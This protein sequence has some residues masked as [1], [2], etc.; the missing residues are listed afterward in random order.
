MTGRVARGDLPR[1]D[2]GG[3]A[4]IAPDAGRDPQDPVDAHHGRARARHA[5]ARRRDHPPV[6]PPAARKRS[7]EQHGEPAP[8][9]RHRRH[10]GS[11]LRARGHP[12]PDERVPLRDDPPDL[13]RVAELVADPRRQAARE[14]RRRR[15]LRCR[16]HGALVRDRLHLPLAAGHPV[17]ARQPRHR[18]AAARHDRGHRDLGGDRRRGRCDRAQPDRRGDRPPGLGLRGREHPVRAPPVRRAVR[19]GTGAERPSGLERRPPAVAG[20]G[21]PGAAC[22]DG[23]LAAIGLVWTSRR[24]VA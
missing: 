2:G 7:R 18:V 4:V 9:A 12:R 6:G 19:S 5:R 11:V 24:D 16:R 14:L 17:R 20:R 3:R 22:V 13:P 8:A 23:V 15:G 10:R 21:R 1:A